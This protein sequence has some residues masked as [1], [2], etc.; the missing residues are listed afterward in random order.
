MKIVTSAILTAVLGAGAWARQI[1]PASAPVVTVCLGR[2]ADGAPD[3]AARSEASRIFY[4]IPVRIAWKNQDACD[5]SDAI[6]VHLT[7]QTPAQRMPGA[8]AFARPY[9]GTY[10]E[11]FHDRILAMARP[12]D[13]PRLLA[14]V[15]AHEITHILQGE[16]RHS[17]A[18]IMK[19]HWRDNDF[20]EMRYGDLTF[21]AED[22]RLVQE[23]LKIRAHRLEALSATHESR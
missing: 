3:Y 6:H 13:R 18:G 21:T 11:I 1:L 8:L 9:Q 14:Y 16:C 2:A 17:D 12:D 19:A 15:L 20:A 10:I 7:G 23:G 4:A 22:I 5:V